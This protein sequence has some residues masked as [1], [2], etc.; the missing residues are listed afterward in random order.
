MNAVLWIL[1][2][3]LAAI[4][5]AAGLFKLTRPIDVLADKLGDWVHDFPPPA[6]RLI[7]AVEV[8]GAVGLIAP[9][10]LDIVPA[11]TAVAAA[12][13]ILAMIG[14][15]VVHLRRREFPAT[16]VNV[17]LLVLAAVVVWGRIGPYAF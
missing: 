10:A 12:G 1:Q 6:I 4:F 7:G 14:A 13:L 8:A 17:V 2:A 9:G 3:L 11:L 5:A 15:I 16:G